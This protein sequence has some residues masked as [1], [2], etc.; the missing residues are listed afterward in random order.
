MGQL[1]KGAVVLSFLKPPPTDIKALI[2]TNSIGFTK[3]LPGLDGKPAAYL[4]I[5]IESRELVAHKLFSR[6]AITVFFGFLISVLVFMLVFLTVLVSIPLSRIS[7]VLKTGQLMS[8]PAMEK[9]AGE[10]GDIWRLISRF[11]EQK[12]ELL[13]EI[14]ERKTVE[15]KL[16]TSEARLSTILKSIGDG[17]IAT[18]NKGYVIFINN[19]AQRL[20]GYGAEAAAGK[21]LRTIFNIVDELT[22]KK[23]D[24]PIDRALQEGVISGFANHTVLI[25]KDGTRYSIDDSAAPIRDEKGNITGAV[26]IFRDITERRRKE[27]INR[28]LA[29]IVQSSDDA[30]VGKTLDGVITDWNKGAE[31]IYGYSEKEIKGKLIFILSPEGRKNEVRDLTERIVKGEKIEHFETVRVRKDGR[32]IDVSLTMSPIYNASGDIVGASAIGRDITERKIMEGKLVATAKEWEVTFDS[33]S[34]LI[35]IHDRDSKLL[36]VNKAYADFF[37]VK[38]EEI[39]GKY[40]YSIVHGTKEPCIDCPHQ[41]TV[42]TKKPA[43]LEYFDSRFNAYLEASTSPIF[44]KNNEVV[45]TVHIIKDI[46]ER[47]KA[48]QKLKEAAELKSHFTSMVSHELRTPLTAIKESISIVA[49]GTAGVLNEEQKDFLGMSKKNVDRLARLINDVLDYQ[50]LESGKL[51]FHIQDND[52]NEIIRETAA[53]MSAVAKEKG[54]E[55]I[56]NLDSKLP[57][58]KCDRDKI[59]QVL[60]NLISNALKFT[61]KGGITVVSEKKDNIVELKVK[62]TGIGIKNE[63]LPRLFRAFEQL[64]Q[65]KERKTGSTGLG[66]AISKEIIDKHRGKIWAESEFGK[67]T[68]FHVILPVI[69]RRI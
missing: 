30:I 11:F 21:D 37:K 24:N 13:S 33:I 53:A 47:K 29:A 55:I 36:R 22:G 68:V 46:T 43:R 7:Q 41:Y 32:H 17:V 25:S 26:L 38:P 62:D 1:T 14:T 10:F 69:E 6:H 4:S 5:N 42:K 27:E 67:G 49:D 9:D 54:L 59:V 63:D 58:V 35:S 15:E 66:L 34:D 65:G 23:T 51:E 18:D 56:L 31:K 12:K 48:E 44:D 39:T 64:A 60:S 45:G 52:M 16:R 2:K 50:K 19:V 20:I 57:L 61:E 3:E 28:R 40:C 8:S